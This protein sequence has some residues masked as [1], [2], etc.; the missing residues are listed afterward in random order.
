MNKK[1]TL[2]LAMISC[3]LWASVFPVVKLLLEELDI[4]SNT[5]GKM[6]LAGMRFFTAG[7][8]IL[9]ASIIMNKKLPLPKKREWT[10][11][12]RVG[13]FQTTGLYGLYYTSIAFVPGVKASIISQGGIFY[14]IIL[15]YFFLG[16]RVRRQHMIGIA[17]GIIGIIVLNLDSLTDVSTLSAFSLKG[18]G[19]LLLSGVFGSLGQITAKKRCHNIPPMTLNGWQ[20]TLGGGVLLIIGS[21]MNRGLVSFPSVFS[22]FLM[23]YSIMVA[24][25]GF[26]LWYFLLLR[27]SVN[28]IVPYRLT[29]PVLGSIFS[30]LFLPGESLTLNIIL[31]LAIVVFGMY[32]ITFFN[33]KDLKVRVDT[34]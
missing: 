33:D 2:I 27:T 5:S 24:A 20:M 14:M 30:A 4:T 29:I 16:E 18:E 3:T 9:I 13:L 1:T 7:I 31:G 15:A 8:L 28:D 26:T 32:I 12:M 34:D 10:N 25:V 6:A 22:L 19:L 11:I 23:S 17:F 21:T